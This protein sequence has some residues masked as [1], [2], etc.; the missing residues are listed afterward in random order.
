MANSAPEAWAKR[1]ECV[2]A[3]VVWFL[4]NPGAGKAFTRN[5]LAAEIAGLYREIPKAAV[6]RLHRTVTNLAKHDPSVA[7][8]VRP[9][10]QRTWRY[11]PNKGKP[12]QTWEWSA[13]DVPDETPAE[14]CQPLDTTPK[15]ATV[16]PCCKR[17]L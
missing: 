16:C 13:P 9:G 5:A 4:R 10:P 12:Y 8:Y 15:P 7:V 1:G 17:P 2:K 14:K 11:G 6:E 3:L